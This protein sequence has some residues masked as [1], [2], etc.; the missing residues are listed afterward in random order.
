MSRSLL[1]LV[2]VWA[3]ALNVRADATNDAFTQGVE[4]SRA[5]EFPEATAAF[6]KAAHLRPAVGTYINLGLSEW[7]RGHA[8]AA[9]L[10]WE[11]ARWI[12]PWDAR[13]VGNLAFARQVAEV[14][15]PQLT[16]FEAAST[17]LPP[18]DWVWVA[19]ASLWLAV[20]ALVLPRILRRNRQGWQQTLAALGLGAFLFSVTANLGVVSRTDI[21]FVV[22]KTAPLLLTPTREGEVVSSLNAGEP[23]RRLR[24]R[25]DYYYLRTAGAAGWIKKS[26][27]GLVS[28]E[29]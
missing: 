26:D 19:G 28:A 17:W 18:N 6:E 21:G 16:W 15:T 5:G 20:G 12:D 13:A 11:Q 1:L 9:I 7:N 8:G 23:G 29:Q 25:G 22:K 3:G 10:A 27:F 24:T 2:L 4:L 14:D